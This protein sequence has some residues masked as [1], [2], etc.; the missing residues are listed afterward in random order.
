MKNHH[1]TKFGIQTR[2]EDYAGRIWNIEDLSELA[3][4]EI[5]VLQLRMVET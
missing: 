4:W 2:F 5:K 1:T 3:S